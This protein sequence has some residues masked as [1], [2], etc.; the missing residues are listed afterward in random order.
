MG[1]LIFNL[2][3]LWVARSASLSG[4]RILGTS[5]PGTYCMVGWVGPMAV[6]DALAKRQNPCPLSG[7]EPRFLCF[8]F[9]NFVTICRLQHPAFFQKGIFL[10]ILMLR[11]VFCLLENEHRHLW[12]DEEHYLS[13][14]TTYV[15]CVI[16]WQV[17]W[18]G[19]IGY[20]HDQSF[21]SRHRAKSYVI[22]FWDEGTIL[23]YG[24]IEKGGDLVMSPCLVQRA[25]VVTHLSIS[26]WA[27]AGVIS[28]EVAHAAVAVIP[29]RHST[30]VTCCLHSIFTANNRKWSYT[31][32]CRADRHVETSATC[33]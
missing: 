27:W 18:T 14:V 22:T 32:S 21:R 24:R 26:S 3:C 31:S 30:I 15:A 17:R 10:L 33:R 4:H 6:M 12:F 13:G 11:F 7:I 1:P 8:T 23:S 29:S 20:C 19:R 2:S 16:G 25:E 5:A 9:C 28:L